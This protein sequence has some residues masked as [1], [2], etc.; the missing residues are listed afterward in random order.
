M[1][2]AKR[3]TKIELNLNDR[4]AGGAN[5]RKREYLFLTRDLL[6]AAR[7]FYV[8]FFLAHSNKLEEKVP[9]WSE[10]DSKFRER[11]LTSNELLTWAESLTVPTKDHPEPLEGWNFSEK[12]PGMPVVY[13]RSVIKDAIGKVRSYLSNY[14]NWEK[15]GKKKGRPGL[16]APRNHPTLYQG[17][18][19][20]DLEKLDRRRNFVAIQV[21][22]GNEWKWCNYPVKFS[23]WQKNRLTEA[24][25][26]NASPRLVLRKKTAELHV[27]QT[28]T[29]EAKKVKDLKEHPR[30]ITVGVDL[31][32][33][34]LAVITVRK[35]GKIIKTVFIKDE[36]FDFHRYRHVKL[37]SKRQWQ[38]G[39]PVKGESSNRLLWGHVRRMNESCAHVVSRRI[40]EVCEWV[41][42]VCPG[43][44]VVVLFERLR[45]IKPQGS[46]SRRLNRKLAN[47]L[48][49]KIIEYTK[50]KAY[51]LGIATAE[52]NPHGTSQ[53]CSR[54]GAK[55]ERFS[56]LDGQR[57]KMKGGKLF[58]CP[59]CGYQVNAD[60]NA[61]VNVHHSF[62]QEFH[63]QPKERA[64]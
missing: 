60:F 43:A 62:Y 36:G 4:T 51:C 27:T 1:G 13:R 64:A 55:G 28:K 53:Y 32:V 18:L 35:D 63:W 22:T 14:R 57:V 25:W 20:L 59:H 46:K 54:C 29:V 6:N 33:K 19:K 11:R 15:T 34:N 42:K 30:L 16:P 5:T 45:R 52:V 48:K 21:W 61:S 40:V 56:Y 37:V 58:C 44:E 2:Q 9:Y 8:D 24:G 7:A 26:E 47:Q 3:T 41:R 38:S 17:T 39:K 50:Y 12:F 23:P 10:K 49:G 31:N